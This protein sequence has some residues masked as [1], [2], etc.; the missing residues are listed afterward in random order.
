M[1]PVTVDAFGSGGSRV[2]LEDRRKR[3]VEAGYNVA[4]AEVG[5]SSRRTNCDDFEPPQGL[6]ANRLFPGRKSR[7]MEFPSPLSDPV[8]SMSCSQSTVMISGS[9]RDT[10]ARHFKRNKLQTRTA[11]FRRLQPMG[12]TVVMG[13]G[14]GMKDDKRQGAAAVWIARPATG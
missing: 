10:K 4:C 2:N 14:E 9:N 6:L 12:E 1:E 8:G 5:D 13:E 7:R 3:L 11:L